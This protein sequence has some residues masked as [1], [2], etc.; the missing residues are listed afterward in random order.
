MAGKYGSNSVTVAYDDAQGGS[1]RTI[2]T[3]LLSIGGIAI[4]A[5]NQV[6]TAYGDTIEKVLPTGV[7]ELPDIDIE[8]MW[9]TTA[10]TG[11][12][13]VFGSVDTDP[14]GGTRTLTMVVGDS[15]TWTSEGYLK[16][17]RVMAQV[18]NITKF[19]AKLSQVSGAWS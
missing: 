19:Q 8:G 17:Y 12:H 9:D 14:N 7:K 1:A 6:V 11:S 15:K 13:A 10:T 5:K 18:G 16:E 4:V 2:T 3:Q